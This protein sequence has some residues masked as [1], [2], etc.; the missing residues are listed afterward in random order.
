[1]RSTRSPISRKRVLTASAPTQGSALPSSVT[2]AC[3]SE[4]DL[5]RQLPKGLPGSGQEHTR[6]DRPGDPLVCALA[7]ELREGERVARR[8]RHPGRPEHDPPLGPAFPTAVRRG[9]RKYR[10]PVGFDWRVDETYSRIGGRW[11]YIY[12]ATD[13]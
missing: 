12:R 8:A 2:P 9:A 3:A 7:T 11:H 1:M 6:K 13:G 4:S 5:R 10:Q